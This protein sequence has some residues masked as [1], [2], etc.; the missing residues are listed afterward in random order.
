MADRSLVI[1]ITGANSGIGLR[2]AER[3]AAEGHRVYALCRDRGR[4]EAALERINRGAATPASLVLADLADPSSIDAAAVR[5]GRETDRLDVLINNAAVFDQTMRTPAFTPAGHELFWA[6][7]H[8][9][10]FQLTAAL[11]GL[12]AAAP[13][14][15]LITVASKGLI[16]MPRIRIRFDAID[17]PDWYSPTRAYYHAKLAQLMTSFQLALRTVGRLDVACV[18]VPAVRLDADRVAAMPWALRTLYAPKNRLSV[19]PQ[20]LAATYA[21][22][23]VRDTRWTDSA[24][25]DGHADARGSL[26]GVY[27]D[28]NERPVTAPA[29]AYDEQARARLWDLTQDAAGGPSWAW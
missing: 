27:V 15:R 22:I 26:R 8:L 28:E 12:L 17:G 19:P 18:R 5:L 23:A 24:D 21:R 25:R 10:P 2:A 3:L 14:P 4:G 20:Q 13:R 6:T 11:S 9:G 29:F 1:A 16:A 7:N